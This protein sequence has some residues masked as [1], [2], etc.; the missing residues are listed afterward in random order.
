L[1]TQRTP[2]RI[3]VVGDDAET[4]RLVTAY[5][6]SD[7]FRVETADSERKLVRLISSRSPDLVLLDLAGSAQ[8]CARL[9]REVKD[10][11]AG[12]SI[13]IIVSAD[14]RML[15]GRAEL[16]AAGADD[17]ISKPYRRIELLLRVD[18]MLW[19]GSLNGKLKQKA[20]ELRSAKALLRK[21]ATTD[22]VT[23]L[24]NKRHFET[25][26]VRELGLAKRREE[27]LSLIRLVIDGLRGF[28][29]RHGSAA[30]DRLLQQ[31]AAI[32]RRQPCNVKLTGRWDSERFVLLFPRMG[33]EEALGLSRT[34]RGRLQELQRQS[35]VSIDTGVIAYPED[36]PDPRA[37]L[38]ALDREFGNRV[39]RRGA[40]SP[41]AAKL[42]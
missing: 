9:C 41:P 22:S 20:I 19:H 3:L 1:A 36:F 26:L 12:R 42:R 11:T 21:Q 16:H 18:S 10:S 27:P 4:L 2:A 39:L 30:G 38:R 29:Q 35:G 25:L 28:H 14:D 7:G 13:P 6:V 5:L 37:M 33:R 23:G 24:H 8:D 15:S 32:V 40:A 31:I 17:F 34:L